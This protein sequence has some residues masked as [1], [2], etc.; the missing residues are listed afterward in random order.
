[1]GG[2]DPIALSGR[3]QNKRPKVN[4]SLAAGYSSWFYAGQS[5][6][7]RPCRDV[8]TIKWQTMSQDPLTALAD[9]DTESP[10]PT[11]SVADKLPPIKPGTTA[12]SQISGSSRM[13]LLS[14]KGIL[15]PP[16]NMHKRKRKRDP[17]D[18]RNLRRVEQP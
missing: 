9:E 5:A 13:I 15:A 11:P 16:H 8:A 12:S 1:M 10:D 18:H 17:I 3:T 6:Y 2:R 7:R 14:A 4:P